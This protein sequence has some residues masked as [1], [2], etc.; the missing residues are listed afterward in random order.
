M[1]WRWAD[2]A[3]SQSAGSAPRA[4][5]ASSSNIGNSFGW[6]LIAAGEPLTI[7]GEGLPSFRHRPRGDWFMEFLTSPT[8]LLLVCTS[9][10]LLLVLVGLAV[11]LLGRK[12][13]PRDPE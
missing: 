10:T 1:F 12:P 8:G 11:R 6:S 4:R 7:I 3:F 9:A 13:A 2:S 5:L